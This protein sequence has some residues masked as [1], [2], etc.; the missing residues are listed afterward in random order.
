MANLGGRVGMGFVTLTAQVGH[1]P[2]RTKTGMLAAAA[3]QPPCGQ[4]GSR[5][6]AWPSGEEAALS[7]ADE[8]AQ[9]VAEQRQLH[10][11]VAV[12]LQRRGAPNDQLRQAVP[13]C[14]DAF[15]GA[16]LLVDGCTW[17]D[18]CSVTGMWWCHAGDSMPGR[19][20]HTSRGVD[21]RT[22]RLRQVNC[23]GSVPAARV[24]G[25]LTA[26]FDHHTLAIGRLLRQLALQVLK[27]RGHVCGRAPQPMLD[28]DQ[29]H[30]GR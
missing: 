8:A 25:A 28:D 15:D 6:R 26:V 29:V 27:Q 30:C 5:H 16:P 19:T 3:R 12:Q 13:A 7:P 17:W 14:I 4:S 22:A 24:F 18:R 21:A 10:H 2:E 11:A 20:V 23:Q 1:H 9:G